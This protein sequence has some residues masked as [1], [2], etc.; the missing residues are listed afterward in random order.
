MQ[1]VGGSGP[2]GTRAAVGV[3]VAALVVW[4]WP[5]GFGGRMLVG[6]DVTRFF[7][8][9]MAVLG[10]SLRAGRLPVWND[11]WG[12]GFP[13]LAESQMGVYYPPHLFLYGLFGVETAY[14]VSLVTHT[15][16]GGLGAFWAARKFGISASGSAL[17]AF[18]WSAGGFF[19]IHMSHPWGYS[20]GSWTPWAWG[21]TWSILMG[22]ARSRSPFV[23][24]LILF[25]QLLPGH[26]QIAFMTQVGIGLILVWR[27]WDAFRSRKEPGLGRAV[28]RSWIPFV[29]VLLALVVAFP[30]AGMQLWPTARLARLANQQRDFSYLAGFAAT[31]FHLVS[32]VAPGLFHYST[33]WR[34]LVW[35]PFITSPEEHLAYVGLAP[36]LLA[37]TAMVRDRKVDAGVRALTFLAVTGSVLSLGPNVPGFG[38]L[39]ELPGFSFF[40]APARWAL[41]V[42]LALALLAGKGFDGWPT[43][44]RPGR[45]I[46]VFVGL[47]AVWIVGIL[48]IIELSLAASARS[49]TAA[50]LRRG[51]QAISWAGPR[52]WDSVVTAARQPIPDPQITDVL[53]K[54]SLPDVSRAMP[55]FAARRTSVYSEELGQTVLILGM[56]AASG[57]LQFSGR[58]RAATPLILLALTFVDLF[59][60][61]RHRMS[62]LETAPWR[63]LTEQSPVLAELARRPRGTRSVDA[64]RNF[65]MI[66]GLAPISSYRTMDL[67]VAVE[68]TQRGH[69]PL[70][71]S[72]TAPTALTAMRVA[73]VGVR[74]FDPVDNLLARYAAQ[75]EG[76]QG[77]GGAGSPQSAWMRGT[78]I[79]DPALAV[80]Q[81]GSAWVARQGSWA[82]TYRLGSSDE[83]PA[84]AWLVDLGGMVGDLPD[85]LAGSETAAM[86][87]VFDRARPLRSE[88]DHPGSR[89]VELEN[90][91]LTG[92]VIVTNLSDP[93]WTARWIGRDGQGEKPAEI[94]PVLRSRRGPPAEGLYPWGWQGI[95]SP[96]PGRWTLALDYD[97]RDVRQGLVIS[98]IAWIG[99][100]G[101]FAWVGRKGR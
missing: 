17:A 63:P 35:D 91:P 22:E 60:L 3:L 69:A 86:T 88:S 97:A 4:L 24:S 14:I 83:P 100:I 15:L 71:F 99:W 96:G 90:A 94:R 81:Y 52:G 64:L 6:G 19:V 33:S 36:L 13:G 25:L 89:T 10:E 43:R 70:D 34:P 98:A 31:P 37:L 82:T 5:I 85:A 41:P 28:A 77:G 44:P 84:R 62:D 39:I 75:V 49:D 12:Y 7:M 74:L 66:A 78:H 58:G 93:Q 18:A 50:V 76:D 80:W 47:A 32:Y 8:G 65:P 48:T 38:M 20:S 68:L 73:G 54:Q 1:T 29:V 95:Q 23:L 26:F 42:S 92:W 45:S 59:L 55:S 11:L 87:G 61:S 9:L 30:L 53:A 101:V 56:L 16:W 27:A 2:L 40:R 57:L 46:A 51:F 67:P 79:D 72:T 21:L